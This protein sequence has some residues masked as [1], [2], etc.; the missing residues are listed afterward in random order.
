MDNRFVRHIVKEFKAYGKSLLLV[1]NPDAF[2]NRDDV[3]SALSKNDIRV[4]DK[5]GIALRV[6]FELTFKE[7]RQRTIY[8]VPYPELLMEDIRNT[9]S[10]MDFH[11]ASY[12][13]E[14]HI[15]TILGS[16]LSIL[17][18]LFANKPRTALNQR[19]T[20]QYLTLLSK[21]E[22]GPSTFN[23]EEFSKQVE[24]L[25]S[26]SNTDWKQVISLLSEGLLHSIGKEY[27]PEVLKIINRANESFQSKLKKRYKQT[28]NAS[29]IKRPQVVS[30][31]QDHLAHGYKDQKIALV[32][33]DGMAYWQY[34]MLKQEFTSDV[35]IKEDFTFSWIPSI[36]QLSRQA[37][38]KGSAPDPAYIQNPGNEEKLW[39]E[40]WSRQGKN[41][42]E[43]RYSHDSIDF[44]GLERVTKY[45]VVLTG[46]D[47]KMHSSE[48]YHDLKILTRN[49]IGKSQIAEKIYFLVKE[50][51][52]VFLTS[53]HGNVP[54]KGWRSLKGKE[55][56]GTSKSGSRSLRHLEYSDQWIA[57]EFINNNP[58]LGDAIVR[59]ENVIYLTNNLSFSSE[60]EMVTH[61]GSYILEVVI[62]F[63]K[64]SHD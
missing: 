39:N 11:I 43:L 38:F 34:L 8:L 18:K 53:D 22:P 23:S 1:K 58:D 42:F 44:V 32:V 5:E 7:D 31:I 17:G 25:L 37:I 45:A 9:G 33:L 20:L 47:E 26:D 2:L 21:A 60:E 56:L 64:I 30:G 49:W 41:K 10:I 14:Y 28:I 48:D 16:E 4:C 52:T 59:E 19:E 57:D 40:Y 24:E 63:V 46:L 51:F 15:K 61:G 55:K 36:T 35:N 12:F 3:K 29:S 13:P 62:P 27:S 50:G 54:A 6:D